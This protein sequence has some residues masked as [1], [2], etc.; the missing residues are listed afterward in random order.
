MFPQHART[1]ASHGNTIQLAT[2]TV[3]AI[4]LALE[5]Q[6]D[7]IKI[8]VEGAEARVLAGSRAIAARRETRFLVEMHSNPAL[9]MLTNA[10]EVLGWCS[11]TGHAAWLLKEHVQVAAAEHIQ[12]RGR[13]HL[14]LQPK[15]W[16]FPA[17]LESIEQGAPIEPALR[18]GSVPDVR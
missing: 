15:E 6:P 12:H 18:S 3:D 17:W 13:C 9:S 1:A 5:V 10:N 16:P 14:L 7:F 2:T 8:D 11:K 4:C